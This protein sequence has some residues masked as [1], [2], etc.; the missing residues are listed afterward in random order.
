MVFETLIRIRSEIIPD[1][2]QCGQGAFC[3]VSWIRGIITPDAQQCG[4]GLRRCRPAWKPGAVE[5]A[6]AGGAA[7]RPLRQAHRRPQQ[8]LQATR[9]CQDHAGQHQQR[10]A[11]KEYL[12]TSMLN[13]TPHG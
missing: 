11:K 13:F 3:L 2:Q 8:A 7:A 1:P 5:P 6:P 4:Q 12:E 10:S 9:L